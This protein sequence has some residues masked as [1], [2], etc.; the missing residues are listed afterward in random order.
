[1]R[2]SSRR[3]AAAALGGLALAAAPVA[4]QAATLALV[5]GIN[6]YTNGPPKL[7]GAV[8]DANDVAQA[9][10]KSG[11]EIVTLLT[12]R[13]ATRQRVFDEWMALVEESSPGDLL[14]FS[15]AG[16][17]INEKDL[18]GD[19]ADGED[20]AYLFADFAD[21]GP[22]SQEQVVDDELETWLAK[23][24]V[25]GRKVLFIADACHSGSP[26]RSIFGETLPTRFYR[27]RTDPERPRPLLKQ[28]APPADQR[29][30]LYAVGAT[31]DDRTVPEIPID[32]QPRGALSFA[33]ARAF[34]GAAD[35]NG[36]GEV[37][38]SEFEAFVEQ[39]VRNLAASKQTPQFEFAD[40]SYP[41]LASVP[42]RAPAA[43]EPDGSAIGVHVRPGGEPGFEQ[44]VAA[45]GGVRL[46]S[47]EASAEL[48]FDPRT[49]DLQNAMRDIV[50]T[51]LNLAGLETAIAAERALRALQKLAIKGTLPIAFSPNDEVHAEG[52]RIGFTVPNVGGR[53][54]TVFDLTATGTMQYLWPQPGDADPYPAGRNFSLDTVVTPPFGA[55][56]LIVLATDQP[57]TKLRGELGRLNGSNDPAAVI[58]S[59]E[60]AVAGVPYDIAI[61]AFFTRSK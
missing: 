1:M 12:D 6:D 37:Q 4:A 14:V 46:V 42:R 44:A 35:L 59:L 49:G 29:G 39:N 23:P 56:N 40:P 2:V 52:T 16:H 36:D 19:E 3:L 41:L 15:F 18:N 34:E 24:G 10:K 21:D 11:A 27:P 5:V 13:D 43:A 50:A 38:A 9:L 7:K 54:L 47:D 30:Y 17:G 60:E 61:Q 28:D 53:Y 22:L 8:N 31:L 26:T 25:A 51:N 33:V 58:S 55:D 45:L 57:P 20:E 32:N 48:V